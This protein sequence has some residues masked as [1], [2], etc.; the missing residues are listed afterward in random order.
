M[1][2]KHEKAGRKLPRLQ[3]VS[4]SIPDGSQEQIRAFYGGLLGF[5]EKQ[6][7]EILAP[8]GLVWFAAGDGEMELH[9]VPDTYL[10]R[11]E[12]ARHFCLEVDDVDAYRVKLE[13]AGYALIEAEVIPHRPRFFL[14]DPAGNHLE[15]TTI[16]ADYN[17]E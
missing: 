11:P 16:L 8:R 15:L 1:Q 5:K 9:F 13:Q 2:S 6:V 4:L 17:E 7:P 12:E 14:V 3:H 10:Q